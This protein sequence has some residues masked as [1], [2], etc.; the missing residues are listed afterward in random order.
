MQ[1]ICKSGI[2]FVVCLFAFRAGPANADQDETDVLA[3]ADQALERITAEDS[4]G[5]TDL[6]IQEAMFYVGTFRDGEYGVRTS[7]YADARARI[8]EVDM[9]ERGFE[10]TVLVSGPIAMVWYPYDFYRDGAWSH[11]GVD[12]FNLVRTNAGWRITTL[13]YNVQQ[14]P[15]CEPHPDGPPPSPAE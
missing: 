13:M 4:V 14:P 7:S 8:S 10:P 3:V 15:A 6:M 11:C 12:I 2:V 1:V 9:V 5:L